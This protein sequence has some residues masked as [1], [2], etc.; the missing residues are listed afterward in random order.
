[1]AMKPWVLQSAHVYITRPIC[2]LANR[3]GY[4][5][6]SGCHYAVE[7]GF[8]GDQPANMVKFKHV[9]LLQL[10]QGR[11]HV[12]VCTFTTTDDTLGLACTCI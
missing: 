8:V 10:N 11:S 5:F 1:M 3:A 2:S 12:R 9:N 6:T 4:L 7:R